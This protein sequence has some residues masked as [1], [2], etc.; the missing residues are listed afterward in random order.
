L[1]FSWSSLVALQSQ[2]P[3]HPIIPV[4]SVIPHTSGIF[5]A[6]LITGRPSNIS[7]FIGLIMVVGIMVVGIV[8]KNGILL[9]DA[10]PKFRVVRESSDETNI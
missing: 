1:G 2:E 7:W 5:V 9:L 10:N 8:S 6:L 3:V 4:A